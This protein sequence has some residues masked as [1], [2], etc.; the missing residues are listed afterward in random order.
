MK[1][2]IIFALLICSFSLALA[3]SPPPTTVRSTGTTEVAF[4][5][6]GAAT[7]TIVK[8]MGEARH[9]LLV[10]AYSFTSAPIAKA[11]VDTMNRGVDVRVVLDKSQ[12]YC[13]VNFPILKF[14]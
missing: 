8:A 3:A 9:T 6:N 14:G 12:R 10:Q 2:I 1:P 5:P 4:S 13:Q 7:E 11:L